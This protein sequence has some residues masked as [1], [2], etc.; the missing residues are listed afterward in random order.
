LIVRHRLSELVLSSAFLLACGA[1][2]SDDTKSPGADGSS[3]PKR[4]GGGGGLSMEAEVG[5]MNES[6]VNASFNKASSGMLE[7]LGKS[8]VPAPSGVVRVVVHV[9][10]SG[11]AVKSF[12]K[13]STVGDRSAEECMLSV[14]RGRSWPT[15]VGGKI[16]IAESELSFDPPSG[17]RAPIDWAEGDAGKNVAAARE[18]LATCR[19]KAKAGPLSATVIVETDGSIVSVGV[20]GEDE[21]SELAAPCVVEGLKAIKLG[22]PGS[23]AAKLTLSPR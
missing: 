17:V 3:G 19:E 12:L 2:P 22:S 9:D 16:G 18:V 8:R 7:C 23:F 6:Q 10:A 5:A 14:V 1:S 13:K 20:S 21:A 4:G 11:S 15:P